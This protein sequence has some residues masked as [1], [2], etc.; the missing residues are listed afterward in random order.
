MAEAAVTFL[1]E[2]LQ[3]LVADQVSLIS[4]A[5]NELEQLQNELDLM[6]SFLE[7]SASKR[8]KGEVFKTLEKQIREIVYSAED[9]IDTCVS[10]AAA[11]WVKRNIKL[12][13]LSLAKE[14]QS[15]RE[16]KVKP[17]FNEARMKF[18]TLQI[19]D[20]PT[21]Q[22]TSDPRKISLLTEK[23]IVGLDDEA[24]KI[25]KYLNEDSKELEV[26]SIIGMP[27]L[28]KT[29]LALK[30]YRDSRIQYEFPTIIWVYVS[31]EYNKKDIFLTILKKFTQQDM[32]RKSE[33]ELAQQVKEYL[34]TGKFL[35]IMD[36]VWTP[37]AWDQIQ[38]ALPKSNRYGKILITSRYENVAWRANRDR[39]PHR[40]RFLNQDESWELLQ[41]EVFGK[42]GVCPPELE[43]TGKLIAEQCDGLPLAIV[44]I[45][46]I[47]VDKLSSVTDTK[48]EW[49]KV[50]D[51]VQT[52]ISNDDK[53]KRMENII[54]LSYNKLP[55]EL[56][57]C[58]LYLGMF[59]EDY[60]IPAW[61]LIRLWI[62]EG[63]VKQ[64]PGKSLE[65]N[66]EDILKEL[67]NRNLVM[68][69]KM[70]PEGEVKTCHVHDMI[71]EFCKRE[72]ALK[73]QNLFEEI[74]MSTD[75]V[76][77]SNISEMQKFRR[78]YITLAPEHI[79]YIIDTFNLLRVFD[80]N[81][82]R[83]KRF[84]TK[85]TELV[86]LR[87]I[88]LSGDDFK[89]LPKDILNLWNLQTIIINTNSRTF[90]IK[91]D[92]LKMMQLRHLKTKA[93]IIL[94]KQGE[95]KTGVN[96][97]TLTRLSP[98]C[99]TEQ[100]F[101]RAPNLKTLGIRGQL[102]SLLDNKSLANLGRLQK[103]KLV[104]DAF[105]RVASENPLQ[106]LPQPDR[107]PPNLRI[108]TLSSTFLD[109]KH[110]SVLGMLN[111]LEVL[112]LKENAFMGKCWEVVAGG[113]NSL[114]FMYIARTDLQLWTVSGKGDHFPKLRCLVL[115][116]CEKL[117]EV[118]TCLVENFRHW[119]WNVSP[120]T[121]LPVPGKI[122]QEKQMKYGE[123]ST[124]RGGFKLI[125]APG[126][127]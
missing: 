32:S 22:D 114:E 96:L 90:E 86:H 92:I 56:R 20:A 65:D 43:I 46:G 85:I 10:Q 103:L 1:L 47:L 27:G 28:G 44:V 95:G 93:A 91:A 17:A 3:Q 21:L 106:A 121:Q 16:E 66:A 50:S 45:G 29:T 117:H 19:A 34:S 52:Y 35:I 2:N 55:Y 101:D 126:D 9:T 72:A 115:K 77:E 81:P 61:K 98:Q 62:A 23:K 108:L 57:D 40:L 74:K 71:R 49:K 89:V 105:P 58:F 79:P 39:V 60:E 99:C 48:T 12:N 4:G 102:L 31:E 53:N 94:T 107:F 118:P 109:W 75:G 63:F 100:V 6:K 112:K 68:V 83:F 41:L 125:I 54:S 59:P 67:V 37:D 51:S 110:M 87:Y 80:V 8:E 38:A 24:D 124:R 30:I 26:I 82:I 36:D 13:R 69:D 84:P 5:Q 33:E 116:N 123:Q 14:V 119:T 70:K 113:F 122:E 76:F 42:E 111:A 127:E 104:N 25:I 15:L 88:A 18:A 97:Q 78:L 120:N 73:N 11:G 7:D 64:K